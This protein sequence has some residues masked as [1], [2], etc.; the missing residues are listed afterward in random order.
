MKTLYLALLACLPLA[1]VAGEGR[2]SKVNGSV[3]VEA[4]QS[5]GDVSTVN[6]SGQMIFILKC[7]T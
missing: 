1:A 3:R 5:A 4:G 7:K 2:V 6:G